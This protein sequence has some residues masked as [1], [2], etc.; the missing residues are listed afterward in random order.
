MML[1]SNDERTKGR[2]VSFAT[3]DEGGRGKH[4]GRIQVTMGLFD[5]P[6][7]YPGRRQ[8]PDID[9]FIAYAAHRG[10]IKR[11]CSVPPEV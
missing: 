4:S 1:L 11:L 2:S 8:P 3:Q 7:R 9:T 6:P 10:D 5:V